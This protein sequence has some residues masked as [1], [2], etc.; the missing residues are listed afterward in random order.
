MPPI[1]APSQASVQPPQAAVHT[2]EPS[3]PIT[4]TTLLS[5]GGRLHLEY[6]VPIGW[7][8][9]TSVAQKVTM[10]RSG[11]ENPGT[12]S[13]VVEKDEIARTNLVYFLKQDGWKGVKMTE[14]VHASNGATRYAVVFSD[15]KERHI[16]FIEIR[17]AGFVGQRVSLTCGVF[18]LYKDADGLG[19]ALQQLFESFR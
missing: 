3:A 16:G 6:S 12:A 11:D 15:S 18:G 19:A 17:S 10:R 9:M 5:E 1:A 8:V 7:E 14:P 4:A 13:C 2:Q